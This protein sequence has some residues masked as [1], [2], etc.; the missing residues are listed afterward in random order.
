MPT[1]FDPP[2]Q[3]EDW[4]SWGLGIGLVLSPW[5]FMFWPETKALENAVVTGALLIALEALTL[6]VLRVWEEGLNIVLG[7]WLIV[8]PFVLGLASS[9]ATALFVIVGLA[10]VVLAVLEMRE[11]RM[12]RPA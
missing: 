10:V 7:L 1:T 3:W 9:A 8:S 12:R 2:R 4:V 5:I 11:I 6:T